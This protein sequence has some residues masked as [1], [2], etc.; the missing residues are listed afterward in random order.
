[1]TGIFFKRDYTPNLEK[2]LFALFE[3]NGARKC[4]YH[5]VWRRIRAKASGVTSI[6]DLRLRYLTEL[7]LSQSLLPKYAK[8]ADKDRDRI[9]LLDK[10]TTYYLNRF[11]KHGLRMAIL[12]NTL[13]TKEDRIK[14]LRKLG[15]SKFIKEVFC[16][17][18]IG[19]AK[20]DVNAYRYALRQLGINS[21]DAIFIGHTNS[22]LDGATK[23]GLTAIR[24]SGSFK[25]LD[26]AI[27]RII[28]DV[29]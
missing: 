4:D 19:Y 16:S 23:A 9:R 28:S 22:E 3:A 17:S 21:K 10:K 12:T 27:Y 7:G 20:P 15:I 25:K 13:N 26:V 6:R 29:I 11:Q 8:I 18:E 5:K 1:M 14:L 2:E 24:F